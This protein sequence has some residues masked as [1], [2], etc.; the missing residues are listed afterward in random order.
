[1]AEVASLPAMAAIRRMAEK[2]GLYPV[3]PCLECRQFGP[4]SVKQL[5]D[6]F[7]VVSCVKGLHRLDGITGF[8]DKEALRAM[9]YET[10]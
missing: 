9:G 3:A 6:G 5:D 10:T 2:F 8:A 1:M 7:L 4:V